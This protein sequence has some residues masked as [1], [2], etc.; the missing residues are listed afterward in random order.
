[1][2]LTRLEFIYGS[3][4]NDRQND[5][6]IMQREC[7]I[8]RE[9]S[10]ITEYVLQKL[11]K[12]NFF[13]VRSIFFYFARW[14]SRGKEITEYDKIMWVATPFGDEY[15]DLGRT[16]RVK[17]I[18]EMLRYGFKK[19]FSYKG[20]DYAVVGD[21]LDGIPDDFCENVFYSRQR[22]SANGYRA[23]VKCIHTMYEA[24]WIIEVYKGRKLIKESLP[25]I[26]GRPDAF[27]FGFYIKRLT[28]DE[29]YGFSLSCDLMKM[30]LTSVKI[31]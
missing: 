9:T 2:K 16:E 26:M 23:K 6:L 28:Y 14:D 5:E 24:K 7:R 27:M 12:E 10:F 13:D 18:V 25:Y 22:C 11:S 31:N 1:M 20:W 8:M 29:K 19:V 21:I 4:A 15:F 30:R 17:F 3:K